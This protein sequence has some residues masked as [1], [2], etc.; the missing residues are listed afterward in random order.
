M[1]TIGPLALN[2]TMIQCK[3][4]KEG[5]IKMKQYHILKIGP[6]QF[7]LNIIHQRSGNCFKRIYQSY[8]DA[9]LDLVQL[10]IQLDPI[11]RIIYNLNSDRLN[12]NEEMKNVS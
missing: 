12:C 8:G 9:V 3:I 11:D 10:G 7:E 1:R 5:S 4:G 6:K 2:R